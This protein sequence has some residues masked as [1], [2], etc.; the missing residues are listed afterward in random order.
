MGDFIADDLDVLDLKGDPDLFNGTMEGVLAE[1]EENPNLK[2]VFPCPAGERK[3]YRKIIYAWMDLNYCAKYRGR[4]SF[5][6]EI[7]A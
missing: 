2:Y 1:L 7:P 3:Y 4:V 6:E 5:L